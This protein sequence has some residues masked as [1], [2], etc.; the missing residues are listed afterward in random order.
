MRALLV[1]LVLSP[2]AAPA[3]AAIMPTEASTTWTVGVPGGIPNA[4]TIHTTIDAGTYGDDST[5]ATSA[6]NTAIQNAG[7]TYDG[8]SIIQVVYLPAGTYRCTTNSINM[9]RSGVVLR[10]AGPG[11]TT[12]HQD[13]TSLNKAAIR[14][15]IYFP[16]YTD[17]AVS[18]S[19]SIAKGDT[20]FTVSDA[21]NFSVGDTLQVDQLD[22]SSYV[23]VGDC[24][25]NKRWA[26]GGDV[27][28]PNSSGGLR[29][30]G[31]QVRIEAKNGNDL[32][33]EGMFHIAFGS[34]FSPE[35]FK[36]STPGDD[37]IEWSGVEDM[38]ITGGDSGN[39]GMLNAR[40]SWVKGV[41]S[42]GLT[43]PGM[44]GKS[45]SVAKCFRSEIRFNYVHGARSISPG[46][47]AYGISLSLQSTGVLVEDNI[48]DNLNK[49]IVSESAG[50][51]NVVAYNYVDE[52]RTTASPDWN[53]N[54]LD[55]SHCSFPTYTLWEGNW[56][57]NGGGDTTHGGM[58]WQTFFR[59]YLYGERRTKTDTGENPRAFGVD[60]YGGKHYVV[61][62]VMLGIVDGG[63]PGAGPRPSNWIARRLVTTRSIAWATLHWA[64]ATERAMKGN[65]PPT[66]SPTTTGTITMTRSRTRAAMTRRCRTPSTLPRN[67]PSS[68]RI[69]GLG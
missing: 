8:N 58:A 25:W 41:E 46:G 64:V 38:T 9:N 13:N 62:N 23:V 15:G 6:I 50:A 55:S 32:D 14:F 31:Q 53:E 56:A 37:G 18:V 67:R 17:G 49:G 24:A 33:I 36:S 65:L 11:T 40:F 30:V 5:D 44:N 21:S 20:S 48:V 61:G 10:G 4:T 43:A 63:A 66:S 60:G 3:L 68:G 26:S 52:A 29:S 59:N 35:A 28:G 19:G 57:Q 69:H 1:L 34:S 12:I 22:D 51:G 27:N 2:L 39:I 42:D 45:I 47:I 16:S 54:A 7:D